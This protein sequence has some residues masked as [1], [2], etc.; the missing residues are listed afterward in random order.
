MLV[1]HAEGDTMHDNL[2]FG[3]RE[4]DVVQG[5]TAFSY[6]SL[7]PRTLSS[8]LSFCICIN[9]EIWWDSFTL[10]RNEVKTLYRNSDLPDLVVTQ[11]GKRQ[12]VEALK[13][14]TFMVR[15]D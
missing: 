2:S 7:A 6:W 11:L 9:Q 10:G 3:T 1:M 12:A 15:S 4:V 13:G 14:L 8:S 5:G